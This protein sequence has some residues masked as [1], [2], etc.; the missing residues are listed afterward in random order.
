METNGGPLVSNQVYDMLDLGKAWLNMDSITNI[1]SLAHMPSTKLP[2]IQRER[3]SI[4]GAHAN[5]IEQFRQMS[6]GM[7]AMNPL[8][9]HSYTTSKFQFM[10]TV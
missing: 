7:Y 1:I 2:M 5:I 6:N 9:K 4:F 3:E 8:S 10:E